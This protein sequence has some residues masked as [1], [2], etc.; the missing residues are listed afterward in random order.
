MSD[1][2]K[3]S[4]FEIS[5][6]PGA[7]FGSV[8]R[9]AEGSGIRDLIAVAEAASEALPSALTQAQGFL[10]LPGMNAINQEPELLVRLSRLFGLEVEN[11]LQTLT[12][13]NAIHTEVPEI[14][15]VSN[16]PP[17]SRMPPERP[18]PPL[19]ADGTIPVQFPLRRGWHTDQSYRRPPPD[20]SL[21]YAMMTASKGQG[22]TCY[23]NGIAAYEALSPEM[24]ERVER[25]EGLHVQPGTGRSEQAVKEGETPRPLAPHESSLAQPVVRAHPV[26]GQRA[27][28]LCEGGQMDW[29]DG[30]LVGMEPGLDG[31]GAKLLYELMTHYTRPE[32]VYAHDWQEGDLVIY[33]NRSMIHAATWFD[34]VAYDRIMW[35]TTVWGNPGEMYD[36]EKRSWVPDGN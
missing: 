21:F 6:L 5:P 20:I 19:T 11:Y 27:L 13:K 29:V 4:A 32:F 33:E 23:A 7:T 18:D 9:L 2:G 17:C 34:A 26:T 22:Q 36:G 15:I 25:L 3:N 30:P 28:Y 24:K 14:L 35:R 16:T 31:D 1:A 10:L 8:V 12:R